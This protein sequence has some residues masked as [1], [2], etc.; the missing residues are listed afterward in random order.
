MTQTNNQRESKRERASERE[1][2]LRIDR[3]DVE[4]SAMC[5]KCTLISLLFAVQCN[6]SGSLVYI[7]Y[8]MY[9]ESDNSVLNHLC[10][11]VVKY[12]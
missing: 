5:M 4:K 11:H 1:N 8:V 7:L 2:G 6:L 12:V 10:P 3:N 9:S